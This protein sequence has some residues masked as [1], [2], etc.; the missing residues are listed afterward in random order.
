MIS[1]VACCHSVKLCAHAARDFRSQQYLAMRQI[2][3][4]SIIQ[5]VS[6]NYNQRNMR[7]WV[8][9]SDLQVS[10]SAFMTKSRSRLE[11]W[12]KSRSRRLWSRLHQLK[13]TV[14]KK[15]VVKVTGLFGSPAVISQSLSDFG[16]PGLFS[17]LSP[18]WRPCIH[19]TLTWT[20]INVFLTKKSDWKWLEFRLPK[21]WP[22]ILLF[23]GCMVMAIIY[24]C[25]FVTQRRKD[26][27]I[28]SLVAY[29]WLKGAFPVLDLFA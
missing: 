21:V 24:S 14:L 29:S 23:C 17:A 9:V 13:C 25:I 6:F 26:H 27:A 28:R 20:H 15:V 8:S 4:C 10:V 19:S 7:S 3:C 11:I 2:F 22:T 1:I 16:A 5:G 12:A 18:S